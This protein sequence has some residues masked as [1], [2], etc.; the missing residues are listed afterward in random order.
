MAQRARWLATAA[1]LFQDRYVVEF[2]KFSARHASGSFRL[3]EFL[4]YELGP[5]WGGDFH[6]AAHLETATLEMFVE[7]L[8]G[9]FVPL[10]LSS[11]HNAAVNASEWISDFIN[12]LS[13][14]PESGATE[15]LQRLEQ[16]PKISAW[17][18]SLRH[19]REAQSRLRSD[20]EY[21]VPTIEEAQWTL[22]GDMPANA[23][24]LAALILDWLDDAADEMRGSAGDP[25]QPFWNVDSHG[26]PERPKPENVCRNAI[27]T[28]LRGRARPL[29]EIELTRESSAAAD[30][31]ADIGVSCSGSRIPIEIKLDS[32]RDLWHA[33]RR[34]LIGQYTTDPAT[35][36]YGVYLILWFG[37]ENVPTPSSGRRPSGPQ[38][39]REMLEQN[40][41]TDEARKISVRVIDVTKP[42]S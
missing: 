3:A 30:K 12:Q 26:R 15:A 34:Q 14:S 4:H 28:A 18:S 23:A 32:S 8:G 9:A 11:D 19:A 5:R 13:A 38:E 41:S 6:F 29:S 10:D 24:D 16:L 40:L 42:G 2:A 1:F 33:L 31:R 20:A 25:W 17:R 21:R 7:V 39:L 35:D 27:L 37:G 22:S 36:G